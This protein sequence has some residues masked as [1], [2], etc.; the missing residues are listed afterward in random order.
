MIAIVVTGCGK[1]PTP[2]T[3]YPPPIPDELPLGS[4]YPA[5]GEGSEVMQPAYPYPEPIDENNI[6]EIQ[7]YP[8][9]APEIPGQ[10]PV[11]AEQRGNVFLDSTE[12][13]LMESYPV[14]VKLYVVGNLPTPCHELR[15]DVLPPDE[16][17]KIHVDIY[18]LT[19][20][21]AVCSQVLEPFDAEILLGDFTEG[22][23]T[24]IVNDV[25]I[26]EFELP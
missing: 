15:T 1:D 2:T 21:D 6:I 20:P 16:E 9:P 3:A 24:V 7:P 22:K 5:P 13:V 23:Y 8:Y 12:I 4:E 18:S 11:D 26:G 25:D 14:Q 19:S 17:N 10:I